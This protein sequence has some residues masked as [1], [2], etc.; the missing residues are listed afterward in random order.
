MFTAATAFAWTGPTAAPPGNNAA[1]PI[2]VSSAAQT[3]AGNLTVSGSVFTPTLYDSTN[4]GYYL[5][6]ANTSNTN[7]MVANELKSNDNLWLHYLGGSGGDWLSNRLTWNGDLYLQWAGQWLSTRLQGY[8]GDCNPP[9]SIATNNFTVNCRACGQ[10]YVMYAWSEVPS[11][12][13]GPGYEAYQPYC[14]QI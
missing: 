14:V 5:Q 10:S 8:G 2:N 12:G 3:K 7:V 9:A 13:S 6:P 4:N 11:T 1:T